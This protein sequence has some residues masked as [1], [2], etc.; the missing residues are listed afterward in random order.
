MPQ[1][2]TMRDLRAKVLKE[3]RSYAAKSCDPE[4]IRISNKV[5]YVF[6]DNYS[7]IVTYLERS[8]RSRESSSI[9]YSEEVNNPE[10][11]GQFHLRFGGYDSTEVTQFYKPLAPHEIPESMNF[12]DLIK[13]DGE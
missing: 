11:S 8:N 2:E 4:L 5:Q 3:L 10:Q 12:V 6:G 7:R 13:D 1:Q 9:V